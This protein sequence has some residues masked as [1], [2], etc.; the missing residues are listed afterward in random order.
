MRVMEAELNIQNIERRVYRGRAHSQP[1]LA[2]YDIYHSGRLIGID[3]NFTP[4]HI[5]R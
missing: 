2:Q 4:N 1:A 3:A 5:P